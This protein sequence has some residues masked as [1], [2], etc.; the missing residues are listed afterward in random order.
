MR[1]RPPAAPL[2]ALVLTACGAGGLGASVDKQAAIDAVQAGF[3][4]AN[5]AGRTGLELSGKAVWLQAGQFD[6]SCVE[7]KNLA[8]ND[9]P[10]ERAAG[11]EGV[12]RISPT[13]DAQR[14]L[15]AS[16]ATGYCVYMG[17]DPAIAIDAEK[18]SWSVDRWRIPVKITMGKASPWF[19][20][21]NGTETARTVEVSDGGGGV[22]K[23]ETALDLHQGACPA[24]LPG[25]EDRVAGTRPTGKPKG[26]PSKADVRKLADAFDQALYAGDFVAALGMVSCVNFFQ[27]PIFGTCA[28][29]DLIAVGPSFQ[30]QPRGQDGTPWLEYAAASAEELSQIQPDRKDPTLFHVVM[31][32]KRT[33]RDRSFAVQW[34]GGSW[35][36]LGVVGK[37]TEALT[38]IRFTYDLH[39][40][41]RRDIFEKR[42]NGELLDEE[43]NHLIP[44]VEEE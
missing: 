16:T 27:D 39:K 6:K 13:Y 20:C 9:D 30:G 38:P 21:L 22:P 15:T 42:R 40:P 29:G 12:P 36:L 37:K 14:F 44:Q 31:K 17:D 11:S 25:G 18:A 7:T 33:G 1:T 4:A 32:S 24:P 23:V 8:F 26:A 35:K 2:L 41:D 10:G 3:T 34:A 43:G 28:V 5:P 19:E